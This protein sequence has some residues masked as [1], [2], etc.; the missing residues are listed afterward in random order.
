VWPM[1]N[2]AWLGRSMQEALILRQSASS[3]LS[4]TGRLRRH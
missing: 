2:D 4:W 1:R 3:L